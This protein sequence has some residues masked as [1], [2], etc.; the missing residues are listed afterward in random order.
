MSFIGGLILGPY[1]LTSGV[2]FVMGAWI[3]ATG[4]WDD[5][6]VWDDSAFWID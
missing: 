3:L 1:G 5:A 6:G 2:N 4:F